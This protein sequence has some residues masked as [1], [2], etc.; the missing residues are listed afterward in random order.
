MRQSEVEA[1]VTEAIQSKR[2]VEV[3][4]IRE[5]DGARTCRMME[6]FD[7][8][9]GRRSTSGEVKFWGWCQTHNS[10]E[11]KTIPNIISIRT[12][13]QKFDPRVRERTFSSPPRYRIPRKW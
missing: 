7:G 2:V 1:I 12:T 8:A 4:Y 10:I 3:D 13:D 6:P 11:Q 5:E 9:P